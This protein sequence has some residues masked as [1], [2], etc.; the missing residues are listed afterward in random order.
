MPPELQLPPWL[1]TLTQLGL[2]GWLV[3]SIV[4][5]VT[6][7]VITRGT[8]DEERADCRDQLQRAEALR[9]EERTARLEA[10]KRLDLAVQATTEQTRLLQ[11]VRVELARAPRRSPRSPDG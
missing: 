8:Y 3:L 1:G 5:L 4:A 7:Q 10:E 9:L 6:R 11:E 2:V